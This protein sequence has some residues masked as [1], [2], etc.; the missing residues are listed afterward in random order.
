MAEIGRSRDSEFI[1]LRELLERSIA[2]GVPDDA[3]DRARE[4]AIAALGDPG[5]P[6]R[7]QAAALLGFTADLL[8]SVVLERGI[9]LSQ[10]GRVIDDIEQMGAVPRL[11]LVREVMQ[12]PELLRLTKPRALE[13]LLGF[14]QAFS[15][16]R[17]V[18]LWS[19][20]PAT[21]SSQLMVAGRPLARRCWAKA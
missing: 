8:V 2:E 6:D 16:L 11:A 13:L 10:L 19:L 9:D 7:T 14:L 12:E 5:A 15:G 3:L 21:T 4:R 18:S 17:S 1:E 20:G